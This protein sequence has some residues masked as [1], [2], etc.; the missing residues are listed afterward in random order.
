MLQIREMVFETNSSS[1]CSFSVLAYRPD[2]INIPKICRIDSN[3]DT[4]LDWAF[5][6]ADVGWSAMFDNTNDLLAFLK[7]AG[8]EQILVDGTPFEPDRER[9][10]SPKGNREDILGRFFAEDKHNF[11]EIV[12]WGSEWEDSDPI[13]AGD[14]YKIQQWKK[15]PNWV[16]KVYDGDSGKE[17]D[18]KDCPISQEEYTDEDIKRFAFW[19]KEKERRKRLEEEKEE[20]W[21]KY[22]A[23]YIEKYGIDPDEFDKMADEADEN[24]DPVSD[25]DEYFDKLQD[26][27]IKAYNKKRYGGKQ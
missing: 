8:V 20:E 22:R 17:V 24:I 27:M 3:G 4:D 5:H 6:M 16:V 18:W 13:W 1:A 7:E 23:E 14:R 12:A 21:K 26:E 11:S 25:A 15:D 10:N 2:T 19:E 9:A